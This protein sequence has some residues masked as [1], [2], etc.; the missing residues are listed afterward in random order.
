MASR[1]FRLHYTLLLAAVPATLFASGLFLWTI[2]PQLRLSLL[3]LQESTLPGCGCSIIGSTAGDKWLFGGLIVAAT[4]VVAFL[5]AFLYQFIRHTTRT[6]RLLNELLLLNTELMLLHGRSVRVTTVDSAAPL[7]FTSGLFHRRII[8][9]NSARSLLS[10]KELNAVLSHEL[11]HIR[12]FDALKKILLFA[13]IDTL[14]FLPRAQQLKQSIELTQEFAADR[15]A[16]VTAKKRTVL[17]AFMHLLQ[18]EQ[19]F[20]AGALPAFALLNE[21]LRYLLSEDVAYPHAS[22]ALLVIS[23]IVILLGLATT[24]VASGG[25]V[26]AASQIDASAARACIQQFEEAQSS[27]SMSYHLSMTCE[28]EITTDNPFQDSEYHPAQ[29]TMPTR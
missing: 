12:R 6:R 28:G 15:A 25:V 2:W 17:S 8:V 16:L 5:L 10:T 20:D 23:S 22:T 7:V 21:R 9:S 19:S 4:I 26:H 18:A 27:P 14:F 3:R 24:F 11:H 13:F 1:L 29:M